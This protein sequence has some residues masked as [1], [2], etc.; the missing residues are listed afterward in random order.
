MFSSRLAVFGRL[1]AFILFLVLTSLSSPSILAD[2]PSPPLSPAPAAS[3]IRLP[4]GEPARLKVPQDVGGR[5]ALMRLRPL[6]VGSGHACAILADNRI[7][8][9]GRNDWSQLGVPNT[10]YSVP[11]PVFVQGLQGEPVTLA[12]GEEH[13]CVALADGRVQCWGSNVNGQLGTGHPSYS[14]QYRAVFVT[15]LAGKVIDLA[16]GSWHTCALLENGHVQ[17]WGANNTG[18]L[19]DG[20]TTGRARPVTVQLPG[21]ATWITAGCNHTCTLLR[22]GRM[23]CWGWNNYKQLGDGTTM[24]RPRPVRVTAVS[25]QGVT[26]EA[27]CVHTCAA[28]VDPQGQRQ[29]SCWGGAS[30]I[31]KP[32]DGWVN[33]LLMRAGL[34]YTCILTQAHDVVCWGDNTYGE[35]GDG[36]YTAHRTITPV[37]GLERKVYYMS[38]GARANFTCAVRDDGMAFCWGSNMWGQMGNGSL[39]LS[40]IPDRVRHL[41]AIRNMDVG[42]SFSCAVLTNGTLDCWGKR[43]NTGFTTDLSVPTRVPDVSGVQDLTLG[44]SHSCV[45]MANGGVRCW[46]DNHYGQLGDGTTTLSTTPVTV[47]HLGGAASAVR[48]GGDFSCA[49]RTDGVVRCWG[50]NH[51][52]QLGNNTT[53]NS[54]RPVTVLL[55]DKATALTAGEHHA[56]AV[57]ADGSVYCWGQNASGQVGDGS[58]QDRTHPVRVHLETRA[59]DVRAGESHTCALLTNGRMWC[60]GEN[61]FGQLGNPSAGWQRPSPVLVQNLGGNVSTLD[62][63]GG[64]TCAVV[65]GG[66]YCWGNNTYGQVGDGSYQ[67]RSLPTPVTGLAAGVKTVRVAWD[68]ACARLDAAHGGHVMCWGSDLFGQLGRARD[69][70]WPRPV[71]LVETPPPYLMAVPVSGRVG[72]VFTITGANVPATEHGRVMVNGHVLTSSLEVNAGGQVRFF[73]DSRNASP[74]DYFVTLQAGGKQATVVLRVRQTGPVRAAQG[75]GTT[76][77]IPGHSAQHARRAYI[78][79]VVR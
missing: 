38:T 53:T 9:W 76:F 27:G 15:G 23:Y 64:S 55:S 36:T 33:L 46:G 39:T 74:G 3:L 47:Q 49:L 68:H 43:F 59:I 50:R 19:G 71:P 14:P 4:N 66:L 11:F 20:S 40:P 1:S 35:L 69:V 56:C 13:T 12:A 58:T 75:G 79:R 22:D 41:P 70:R 8:C 10:M 65:S 62:A 51:H 28:Y 30:N 2:S 24:T 32:S 26:I 34:M 77:V 37:I 63:G 44:E 52:G 16:A 57:L 54:L 72:S 67:R 42:S 45:L 25:G 7:I 29:V 73:V 61:V 17:C 48:V 60:W 78:P 18:Q 21:P 31:I 5:Q 6:S